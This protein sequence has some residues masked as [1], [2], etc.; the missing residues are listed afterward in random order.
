MVMPA[1]DYNKA[2]KVLNNVYWIGFYDS[3]A[4]LHCN[5]FLPSSLTTQGL[6]PS[7]VETSLAQIYRAK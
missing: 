2:I 7:S 1:Y 3:E 4:E 5:P 6:K